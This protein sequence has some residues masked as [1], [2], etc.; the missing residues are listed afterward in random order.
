M[1]D[2]SN[3]LYRLDGVAH[4]AGAIHLESHHCITSLGRQHGMALDDRIILYLQMVGLYHLARLNETWFRL[5]ESLVSAF[6]E[7]WRIETHTFHMSFGEYTITLQDV[8]Y[9]L[10]LAIDGQCMCRVANRNVVKLAGILQLLH[11][12]IFWRFP[13]F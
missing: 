2:D 6:V 5:D 10:G 3:R 12:W 1:E 7:I 13:G 11:S 9:Q 4:T 8:A